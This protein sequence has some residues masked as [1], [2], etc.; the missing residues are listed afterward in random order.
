[1]KQPRNGA[2]YQLLSPIN[3]HW[4]ACKFLP[5]SLYRHKQSRS[6]RF[7]IKGF[8]NLGRFAK[9]AL[10]TVSFVPPH[11]SKC[12]LTKFSIELYIVDKVEVDNSRPF[13]YRG[14]N[15][16]II[17]RPR[18][19]YSSWSQ[20]TTVHLWTKLFIDFQFQ[21]SHLNTCGQYLRAVRFLCLGTMPCSPQ[22]ATSAHHHPVKSAW[23]SLKN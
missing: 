10:V 11:N 19:H 17:S 3:F 16:T 15:R 13:R 4:T 21:A 1:M 12:M 6:T 2:N 23:M 5:Y 20:V 8:P 7:V 22:E 14:I 18:G 9:I